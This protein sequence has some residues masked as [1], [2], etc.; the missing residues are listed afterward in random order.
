[1]RLKSHPK[2]LFGVAGGALLAS[3]LGLGVVGSDGWVLRAFHSP[4]VADAWQLQGA[5]VAQRVVAGDEAFWLS[6][7]GAK[8]LTPVVETTSVL[9]N[10]VA[11]DFERGARITISGTH[12][13]RLDVVSI[14]PSPI[15]AA[16]VEGHGRPLIL[17]TARDAADTGRLVRFWVEDAVG[18]S[19]ATSTANKAL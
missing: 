14:T 3:G 4:S 15:G 16:L 17:V 19:D 2:L 7:A 13:R 6:P 11:K 5:K 10:G 9:N 18:E 12:E 8:A 1:M